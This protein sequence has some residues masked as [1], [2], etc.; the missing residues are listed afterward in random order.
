MAQFQ[1]FGCQLEQ[2]RLDPFR[3]GPCPALLACPGSE[4]SAGLQEIHSQSQ[5][6]CTPQRLSS[7]ACR[8]DRFLQRAWDRVPP[9]CPRRSRALSLAS[10][11]PEKEASPVFTEHYVF[12]YTFLPTF[13]I[14]VGLSTVSQIRCFS[15]TF[16][17]HFQ[18]STETPF[19]IN[20][21][22]TRAS[23]TNKQ[24]PK[25]Q[26]LVS[27]TNN[28][29]RYSCRGLRNLSSKT[30]VVLHWNYVISVPLWHAFAWIPRHKYVKYYKNKNVWLPHTV[31]V[32]KPN[33]QS[34]AL[35]TYFIG[36][37]RTQCTYFLFNWTSKPYTCS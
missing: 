28:A 6:S 33:I 37:I 29:N 4:T 19:P 20:S 32:F 36:L 14:E 1:R 26:N 31:E 34:M 23:G 11:L 25:N 18:S 27:E 9:S 21:V 35:M 22:I 12:F 30:Q 5:S 10:H 8:F 17:E 24:V 13:S 2:R 15:T 16:H 3:W 7:T